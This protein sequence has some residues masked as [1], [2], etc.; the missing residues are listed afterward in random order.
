MKTARVTK[1]TIG[2]GVM[3]KLWAERSAI[4]H[5]QWR[6]EL[7]KK[8]G[9]LC[10]YCEEPMKRKGP[11]ACTL[12]HLIPL[13]RGGKDIKRNCVAACFT[14]NQAKGDLTFAEIDKLFEGADGVA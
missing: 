12:D 11:K 4:L 2:N 9:G 14:C 6:Y 8:Q 3:G 7:S 10:Y 13:S 1:G 5:S